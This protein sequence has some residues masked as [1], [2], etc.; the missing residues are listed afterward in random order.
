MSR[1]V[2]HQ[3]AIMAGMMTAREWADA[4]ITLDADLQDDIECI[5]KM[6]KAYEAGYDIVYGV[7]VSREAIPS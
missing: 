3:N 7:K 5:P 6:V 4:V 1:N 2:G